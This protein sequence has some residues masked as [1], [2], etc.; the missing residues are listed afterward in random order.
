MCLNDGK[1]VSVAGAQE[2]EWED[3]GR[4]AQRGD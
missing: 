1:N 4:C 3:G 2:A